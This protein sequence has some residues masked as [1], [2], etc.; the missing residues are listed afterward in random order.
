MTESV[1][2][3][4]FSTCPRCAGQDQVGQL[5][6]YIGRQYICTNCG[7]IFSSLTQ[8]LRE[9]N[10][11]RIADN[12]RADAEFRR[13][14]LIKNRKT[15]AVHSGAGGGATKRPQLCFEFAVVECSKCGQEYNEFN[16]V[17]LRVKDRKEIAWIC[18]DQQFY[19][20]RCQC[21]NDEL[22]QV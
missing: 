6:H 5:D 20:P 13:A 9:Q 10:A 3:S 4:T 8:I 14:E 12:A 11:V 18:K 17:L 7:A 1:K 19:C 22:I 16:R 15:G 2:N 21:P